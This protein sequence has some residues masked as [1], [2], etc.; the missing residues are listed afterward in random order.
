MSQAHAARPDQAGAAADERRERR[1][2][3][4]FDER[5]PG[6]QWRLFVQ[7]AGH[8]MH[9]C[10]LQGRFRAQ[11]RQQAGQPRSQHGFSAARA[12]RSWQGDGRRRRPARAPSGPRAAR[13]H[14]PCPAP[15]VPLPPTAG[16]ASIN[17]SLSPLRKPTRSARWATPRTRTPPAN[18]A[19][20]RFPIGTMA[21]VR[22]AA[23]R[24]NRLGK[25][26]CTGCTRPSRPSSPI[27]T[28][29]PSCSGRYHLGGGQYGHRQGQVEAGS[30]LRQGGRGQRQRDP[31]FRPF[32][33][34]VDHRGP[35]PITGLGHRHITQPDHR[36]G[37]QPVGQV[38]LHRHQLAGHPCQCHRP[39]S[40]QRHRSPPPPS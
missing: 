40:S 22:P 38:C 2:V 18:A 37:G 23:C 11:P 31:A 12:A 26:P 35:N 6:D 28:V 24:A 15:V 1:R 8:R 10:H 39:G 7:G 9:R 21:V 16:D 4:G 33:A 14:R 34:R 25:V 19:S 13:A 36:G 20:A 29:S 3:V 32:R 30:P 17:R 27:N 5:R